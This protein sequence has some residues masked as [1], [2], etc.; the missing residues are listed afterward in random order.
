M[1]VGAGGGPVGGRWGPWGGGGAGQ[2]GGVAVGLL[3]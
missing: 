1:K 2:L 3:G